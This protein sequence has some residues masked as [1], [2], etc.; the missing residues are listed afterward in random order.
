MTHV[1][2]YKRK[3]KSTPDANLEG[4]GIED[5]EKEEKNGRDATW[6]KKKKQGGRTMN[7]QWGGDFSMGK[8]ILLG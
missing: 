7:W 5:Y 8:K 6:K 1:N 2:N 4:Y 3:S